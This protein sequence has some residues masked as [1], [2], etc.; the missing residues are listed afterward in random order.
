MQRFLV[1]HVHSQVTE[2]PDTKTANIESSI[3]KKLFPVVDII[4]RIPHYHVAQFEKWTTL[5]L[6]RRE[7]EIPLAHPT[8]YARFFGRRSRGGRK[9]CP[10]TE[11]DGV[12]RPFSRL[13]ARKVSSDKGGTLPIYGSNTSAACTGFLL[14][15]GQA[16]NSPASLQTWK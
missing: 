3:S 5:S 9:S 7:K 14:A 10:K 12:S 15:S 1:A 2:T 16:R 6:L 4:G 11:F 8:L 13:F